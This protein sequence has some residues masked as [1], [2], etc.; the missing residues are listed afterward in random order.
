MNDT[1]RG[2]ALMVGSMACFA[3]EDGL[4]KG[5]SGAFP[6]AQIIWMLGLGGALAFALWLVL[7]RQRVWSAHYLRPQVLLRTGFEV[8]GTC[9][10]VSSLALLPLALASAIIQATP[11]VVAMGAALF[12]GATVGWRRWLAIL[13]GF[14]GVLIIIRP[15]G[16]GFDPSTL[17]AVAG[18]LGLAGRDLVTRTMPGA[19][20]GARLSLHAFAALVPGGLLLQWALGAAPVMPDAGQFGLLAVCVCIGMAGYLTIVAATRLGDISVVSSFRYSRMLFAL[21]VGGIAFGER[22]DIATILGVIIVI[23][24]GVFTLLREARL[25]TA[26]QA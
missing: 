4:I 7:S 12:L 13:V 16:A 25:R 24:S 20:S 3:V 17:L 6:P 10:F 14:A 15:G 1:L 19:V 11:L 26:S 23:G 9:C 2:A 18:M 8:L 5:L 22:P 21:V